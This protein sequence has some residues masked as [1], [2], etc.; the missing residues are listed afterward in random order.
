[1][2]GSFINNLIKE[3]NRRTTFPRSIENVANSLLGITNIR[4]VDLCSTERI[5]RSFTCCGNGA[6]LKSIVQGSGY[7]LSIAIT[8]LIMTLEVD[9]DARRI[10]EQ[11]Y[12]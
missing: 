7:R 11:A 4:R 6:R 8:V 10:E 12:I 3:N 9:M 2:G 5:E 1:M